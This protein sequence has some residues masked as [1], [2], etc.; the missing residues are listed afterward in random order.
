MCYFFSATGCKQCKLTEEYV[1]AGL[2]VH[3]VTK[4]GLMRTLFPP[5]FRYFFKW[6]YDGMIVVLCR[7]SKTDAY[8]F[9]TYSPSFPLVYQ[10]DMDVIVQSPRTDMNPGHVSSFVMLAACCGECQRERFCSLH[11]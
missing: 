5:L 8:Y 10:L 6:I 11:L 4:L 9:G 7:I 2:L 1:R 3:R